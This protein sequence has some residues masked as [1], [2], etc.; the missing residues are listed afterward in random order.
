MAVMA[1][2]PNMEPKYF[3]VLYQKLFV[4]SLPICSPRA[5]KFAFSAIYSCSPISIYLKLFKVK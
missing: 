3:V 1:K 5:G 2:P 4:A